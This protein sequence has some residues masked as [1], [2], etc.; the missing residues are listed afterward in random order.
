[1]TAATTSAWT[2]DNAGI[3]FPTPLPIVIIG[4]GASGLATA[5]F[6]RRLN[7][8]ARVVLVDGAR[9]P[10]AKILVSGGGRCNVTNVRVDERDFSGGSRG[11]V[12]QVLKSL[13]IPETVAFFNTIGVPLHEEADG[14]L[15][16]DSGR[17]KQV[18]DALLR[19][20]DRCGVERLDAHRV[21]SIERTG[22]TFELHSAGA[23]TM[24][25]RFIVLATGGQSLP[26][27]GSDGAGFEFAR[28]LG[29]TV[30]PPV[31]ALVPLLLDPGSPLAHASIA[32]V[33]HPSEIAVWLDR[34]VT[35]R[36]SGSL[37]WT[38]FGVSGPAA[39][40]VSRYWT[41]A[42]AEGQKVQLTLNFCPGLAFDGVDAQLVRFICERP[43]ASLHTIASGMVPAAVAVA[44]LRALELQP[45][46]P[47]GA[48]TR[49]ARRRLAHGFTQWTLPVVGTRGYTFA[50]VTAGGVALS[51]VDSRTLESRVCR[52]LYLVGEVLDVDGR[53]GGF[54][55]QWAWS[56]GSVAA[57]ALATAAARSDSSS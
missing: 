30:V 31:P 6:T 47:S 17:A 4:A 56:T 49:D 5:I 36:V 12:R 11:F 35:E 52:G 34:R 33:S 53:L 23:T 55:F 29:H 38:H 10:G 20:S 26:K 16:P 43:R 42:T 51:E 3:T 8:S 19:E 1:M 57:R 46:E 15:F 2:R 39:L 9:R 44:L 37:L 22:D 50:E 32:G 48:L 18:L 25:A 27:S 45:V 24:Q 54:N 7:P 14:K 21:D 41:R 13:T 40:D 28:R